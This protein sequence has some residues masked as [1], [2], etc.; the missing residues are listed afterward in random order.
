MSTTTNNN[1]INLLGGVFISADKDVK[2][3]PLTEALA[4]RLMSAKG[5]KLSDQQLMI[6]GTG[7]NQYH[8]ASLITPSGEQCWVN[9]PVGYSKFKWNN[10]Q[11]WALIEPEP[12]VMTQQQWE[13]L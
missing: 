2:L 5:S 12:I 6:I 4:V 10:N 13:S 3:T 1:V 11:A 8:T 7:N 9:I